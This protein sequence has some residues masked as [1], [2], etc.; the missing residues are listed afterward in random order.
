MQR[1]FKLE[2]YVGKLIMS[3]LNTYVKLRDDQVA[4]SIWEGDVILN[5]LELRCESVENLFPIPVGLRLG[6]VRELRI[7]VPWTKLNS[8]NIVISLHTVECVLTLK[9]PQSC[10]LT[11][12]PVLSSTEPP[13]SEYNPDQNI[14]P[15]YLQSYLHRLLANIRIVVYN[16]SIKF[17]LD[18]IVL[19]LSCNL[20][21]FYPT[22]HEWKITFQ[23]TPSDSST[24]VRR[25]LQVSDVTICL[26]HCGP[27]GYV[28]TYEQPLVYRFS[29]SC[30]IELVYPPGL[31]FFKAS[32]ATIT[33][34]DVHAQTLEVRLSP[35]QVHALVR[36]LE[37]FA[38]VH[39]ENVDWSKLAPVNMSHLTE[40]DAEK[41]TKDVPEITDNPSDMSPADQ[42]NQQSWA[43]WMW[44]LVPNILPP[45][46]ELSNS[47]GDD[48]DD[49]QQSGGT[50]PTCV[51]LIHLV[52]EDAKQHMDSTFETPHFPNS[53]SSADLPDLVESSV[54]PVVTKHSSASDL[55]LPV[56]PGTNEPSISLRRVRHRIR[57][58]RRNDDN[59]PLFVVGVF[60]DQLIVRLL[61][62]NDQLMD[63]SLARL[64]ASSSK[65][66]RCFSQSGLEVTVRGLALQATSLGAHFTS[67]QLGA[68]HISA[69]PIGPSC[70][71]GY[72]DLA[73]TFVPED[74]DSNSPSPKASVEHS[75]QTFL[76]L[77]DPMDAQADPVHL[78]RVFH[79]VLHS[80]T[81]FDEDPMS[82]PPLSVETYLSRFHDSFVC[83]EYPALWFDLITSMDSENPDIRLNQLPRIR[84]GQTDGVTER[85][86]LRV[87]SNQSLVYLSPTILHRFEAFIKS[88]KRHPRYPCCLK[89]SSPAPSE[90]PP[91]IRSQL[92][93]FFDGIAVQT[94]RVVI[95]SPTVYYFAEHWNNNFTETPHLRFQSDNITW[96]RI[97]PLYPLEV[98]NHLK[99]WR[100]SETILRRMT[101]CLMTEAS[102]PTE[103]KPSGVISSSEPEI[104]MHAFRRGCI[105]LSTVLLHLLPGTVSPSNEI[106]L[107]SLSKLTWY[108]WTLNSPELWSHSP[109]LSH[110]P[111]FEWRLV[112]RDSLEIRL[113]A[114]W[115]L[116]TVY[117]ATSVATQVGNLARFLSAST[118]RDCP[119]FASAGRCEGF[120]FT[121]KSSDSINNVQL[122]ADLPGVIRARTFWNSS[123]C[124]YQLSVQTDLAVY[125]RF[126]DCGIIVPI[127][128]RDPSLQ[129][130]RPCF[131]LNDGP[132]LHPAED[133]PLVGLACQFPNDALNFSIP[134]LF[135]VSVCGLE[136]HVTP[137]LVSWFCFALNICESDELSLPG[138][139]S[140]PV[141]HEYGFPWVTTCLNQGSSSSVSEPISAA[142][143]LF[144]PIPK[145]V[146]PAERVSR[147][148]TCE[149]FC[150][151]SRL[152]TDEFQHTV[153]GDP[154]SWLTIRRFLNGTHQLLMKTSIQISMMPSKLVVSANPVTHQVPGKILH[155]G[156]RSTFFDPVSTTVSLSELL[157]NNS[158][159]DDLPTPT[160]PDSFDSLGLVSSSRSWLDATSALPS[161]TPPGVPPKKCGAWVLCLRNVCLKVDKQLL[162][163]GT[164]LV[165]VDFKLR[166]PQGQLVHSSVTVASSLDA[167]VHAQLNCDDFG[168]HDLEMPSVL[169]LFQLG[170]SIK[171]L[172][173]SWK[174]MIP[175]L[176]LL[177]EWWSN[178]RV[179]PTSNAS[180][181]R[182]L[183]I[184]RTALSSGC[185][186]R[187]FVSSYRDDHVAYWKGP[188][189][190]VPHA[191]QTSVSGVRHLCLSPQLIVT[192]NVPPVSLLF[193]FTIPTAIGRLKLPPSSGCTTT[194][195]W[196]LNQLVLS[197]RLRQDEFI[198]DF[199]I[200]SACA[201]FRGQDNAYMPLF[202]TMESSLRPLVDGELPTGLDSPDVP[203]IPESSTKSPPSQFADSESEES[204]FGTR[205]L[206]FLTKSAFGAQ[207][208]CYDSLSQLASGKE[209]SLV[210]LHFCRSSLPPYQ[211][212]HEFCTSTLSSSPVQFVNTLILNVQ[213]VDL[214]LYTDM[215]DE[216]VRFYANLYPGAD[217]SMEP[218]DHSPGAE[219]EEPAAAV[220]IHVPTTT[221]RS[222]ILIKSFRIFLPLSKDLTPQISTE[223]PLANAVVLGCEMIE[224][225]PLV[226]NKLERPSGKLASSQ[227]P[228]SSLAEHE[229]PQQ[230]IVVA[231]GLCC[232]ASEFYS[233]LLPD[234]FGHQKHVLAE[235]QNP[236]QYWNQGIL[237]TSW[238]CTPSPAA[239][240]PLV[241]PFTL[242]ASFAPASRHTNNTVRTYGSA[243]E[244]AIPDNLVI[245]ADFTV[246]EALLANT[247]SRKQSEPSGPIQETKDDWVCS[248]QVTI[249]NDSI[250]TAL[251]RF[252]FTLRH[253]RLIVWRSDSVRKCT[254]QLVCDADHTHM[255]V[256]FKSTYMLDQLNFGVHDVQVDARTVTSECLASG[257]YCP[258]WVRCHPLRFNGGSYQHRDTLVL[259]PY[260]MLGA[261]PS[262]L[263]STPSSDLLLRT[264][265]CEPDPRTGIFSPLVSARI[266]R[267]KKAFTKDL[268]QDGTTD[269][270]FG[271]SV[272]F[273]RIV[274]FTI[275]PEIL[276][277]F[278]CLF[279]IRDTN[280][281]GDSA[282]RSSQ[283]HMPD[284][285][286]YA[287]TW[288]SQ[289]S[290]DTDVL[291]ILLEKTNCNQA[292]NIE[293]NIRKTH[294]NSTFTPSEGFSDCARW[295][296]D[297]NGLHLSC[298]SYNRQQS[299]LGLSGS[300]AS[301]ASE[302]VN[303]HLSL[304][305]PGTNLHCAGAVRVVSCIHLTP[306]RPSRFILET[307]CLFTTGTGVNVDIPIC[308]PVFSMIT[309]LLTDFSAVFPLPSTSSPSLS[310]KD[311]FPFCDQCAGMQPFLFHDDLRRGLPVQASSDDRNLK[312][313]N[314]VQLGPLHPC[315]PW[316][317]NSVDLDQSP[318]CPHPWPLAGEVVF[319]DNMQRQYHFDGHTYPIVLNCNRPVD[320]H[321]VGVTWA[322]SDPRTPVRVRVLPAPFEFLEH[323][324]NVPYSHG[325][326][327]RCH[328]QYWDYSVMPNGKFKDYG[329]FFLRDSQV[330]DFLL[331]NK[332]IAEV[333]RDDSAA[334]ASVTQ[335]DS[336]MRQRVSSILD[337]AIQK[338]RTPASLKTG[339]FTFKRSKLR[340]TNGGIRVSAHVWRIMVDL[341]AQPVVLRAQGNGHSASTSTPPITAALVYISPLV[342][343]G[344][345]ELDSVRQAPTVPQMPSMGIFYSPY[346]RIGLFRQSENCRQGFSDCLELARLELEN[347][348]VSHELTGRNS[349]V[350]SAYHYGCR[351]TSGHCLLADP[352][353]A[354]L[355]PAAHV[356]EFDS[357]VTRIS[358]TNRCDVKLN[359]CDIHILLGVD[360]LTSLS[361]LT[362]FLTHTANT[363]RS[364]CSLPIGTPHIG[365]G[366]RVANYSDQIVILRQTGLQSRTSD[367][368]DHPLLARGNSGLDALLLFVIC[369]AATE[370]W[371]PLPLPASA[372]QPVASGRIR[373]HVGTHSVH[374]NAENA[375][376]S[377]AVELAWPPCR[378]DSQHGS[379]GYLVLTLSWESS[380]SKRPRSS[381]PNMF[382]IL[383]QPDPTGFPGRIIF[384]SDIVFRNLIPVD[385]R[386]QLS[387]EPLPVDSV[388]SV[389]P[390]E[391]PLDR[392]EPVK[393]FQLTQGPSENYVCSS[394]SAAC[395]RLSKL[396]HTFRLSTSQSEHRVD[397]KGRWSEPSVFCHIPFPSRNSRRRISQRS[398]VGIPID[399]EDGSDLFYAVVT[400]ESLVI[401]PF[402][403]LMCMVTISPSFNIVSF[404]PH[405]F[406]LCVRPVY[407]YTSTAD[408][409][410]ELLSDIKP[411][412]MHQI[413]P[414]SYPSRPPQ[415]EKIEL[416]K[417][418]SSPFF[419]GKAPALLLNAYL[420][421][422]I[423]LLSEPIH[424]SPD[425]L[426]TKLAT[427]FISATVP[428]GSMMLNG[429]EIE[430]H[431]HKPSHPVVYTLNHRYPLYRPRSTLFVASE[432]DT[433][434]YTL[435]IIL[436]PRLRLFN[437]SGADLC[438][439]FLSNPKGHSTEVHEFPTGSVI[440]PGSDKPIVQFGFVVKA[441]AHWS[442]VTFQLSP[443]LV[444][445]PM[446]DSLAEFPNIQTD[447]TAERVKAQNVLIECRDTDTLECP[448]T[449]VE[450]VEHSN[451]MVTVRTESEGG[452]M[453][454]TIFSDRILLCL[455]ARLIKE[456]GF[457]LIVESQVR[458]HH[459]CAPDLYVRPI[460]LSGERQSTYD[461]ELVLSN[462]LVNQTGLR[463]TGNL[464][465]LPYWTLSCSMTN[466]PE[467][468]I[469]HKFALWIG[470][471][472]TKGVFCE[473]PNVLPGGTKSS[474]STQHIDPQMLYLPT[475]GTDMENREYDLIV[476]V[477][478]ISC[479]GQVVVQL[480]DLPNQYMNSPV[481]VR[482]VNQT[483]VDLVVSVNHTSQHH[484]TNTGASCFP[485]EPLLNLPSLG[486]SQIWI[487]NNILNA[488]F[489]TERSQTEDNTVPAQ[490]LPIFDISTFRDYTI[491]LG[492]KSDSHS[493]GSLVFIP[494]ASL[495]ESD[496]HHTCLLAQ[497]GGGP[498]TVQLT[499]QINSPLGPCLFIFPSDRPPSMLPEISSFE[500]S[501]CLRLKQLQVS[502]LVFEPVNSMRPS[503]PRYT[504]TVTS[505]FCLSGSLAPP[506]DEFVRLLLRNLSIDS[507]FFFSE[508]KINQ[509]DTVLYTEHIQLDNW[510]QTWTS[511]YD[512]PTVFCSTSPAG[513]CGRFRTSSHTLS[514]PVC[515]LFFAPPELQLSLED[516]LLYDLYAL[517]LSFT[518]VWSLYPPQLSSRA[519]TPQP[520]L[521]LFLQHFYVDR[522][523]LRVSLRVMLRVY[524]SCHEAPLSVAPFD[525]NKQRT[526]TSA[527]GVA[528]TISTLGRLLGVHYFT[529][530]MFRAGWLVGSLDVLGNISG[531]LHSLLCGL[532]ALVN[533]RSQTDPPSSVVSTSHR[534]L[535]DSEISAMTVNGDPRTNVEYVFLD[536]NS[537][538]T[539][540]SPEELDLQRQ[541]TIRRAALLRRFSNGIVSLTRHTTGGLIRSVTG[542]A[543]SVARNL[544]HLSLD[545]QHQQRQEEIRRKQVPRGLGEGLQRGLSGFGLC[546]L[547]AIAGVAD[548]PLQALF[549]A[550]DNTPSP[551]D[552][553]DELTENT[554][555]HQSSHLALATLGGLGRGLVGA[556]VKPMAGV[557]ELVAQAGTGILQASRLGYPSTVTRQANGPYT[558]S[559]VESL[560]QCL[561]ADTLLLRSW[562]L[563]ALKVMWHGE[564]SHG[565]SNLENSNDLW[566]QLMWVAPALISQSYSNRNGR[567]TGET[568]E[569]I[570]VCAAQVP[571]LVGSLL[572]DRETGSF[573]LFT[574]MAK[575]FEHASESSTGHPPLFAGLYRKS[576]GRGKA[577][578]WLSTVRVTPKT[579]QALT[580]IASLFWPPVE[581]DGRD[582]MVTAEG[583]SCTVPVPLTS[584]PSGYPEPHS[585]LTCIGPRL[586]PSRWQRVK[587]Y[588][589][590]TNSAAPI[591]I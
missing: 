153:F 8:E 343:A 192:T 240:S 368:P 222:Y 80:P 520:P 241:R 531:L 413:L 30:L 143:S 506:Q 590:S 523:D 416:P 370:T 365:L 113:P 66:S 272:I 124:V 350:Q 524:L 180:C 109:D 315:W 565:M 362:S 501:L 566:K 573:Q 302:C 48:D 314:P 543:A 228:P 190:P 549:K 282:T 519:I 120:P 202:S 477:Q 298:C 39:T 324:A 119:T 181:F 574:L 411:P 525:L 537:D 126:S 230:V 385:I 541:I 31:D 216:I 273:G 60:T 170:T 494:L 18:D 377:E 510:G 280:Q 353:W 373:F 317:V 294:L 440:S 249:P 415:T 546:V 338:N 319:C 322:Y 479:D 556:V 137:E 464:F 328:L 152:I 238:N 482:L 342:L 186:R 453:R 438:V 374:A 355:K 210:H 19:S 542:M 69:F 403:P 224:I 223:A 62:P 156:F 555:L 487:P 7:H 251:S 172:V 386:A 155:Q 509:L 354:K 474:N 584:P 118:A 463:P 114:D 78:R 285:I 484:S 283:H 150:S 431:Y 381:Y 74:H 194:V 278:T 122:C 158:K 589:L 376:W 184:T 379:N 242:T 503:D 545:Q 533:L 108:S 92:P 451:S 217:A 469:Q 218:T 132:Y 209:T 55:R 166:F 483:N 289:L 358:D 327:L 88:V 526:S 235:Q 277:T 389:H 178:N 139:N 461:E 316:V 456:K 211:H 261:W 243:T 321:W 367:L 185:A 64:N 394:S 103:A 226:C 52:Y 233:L 53:F 125:L 270:R 333:R 247:Q 221:F 304:L 91:L 554:G 107:L 244:V 142:S 397:S 195:Y 245:F 205:H 388:P 420:P 547:G 412:W 429:S 561:A 452:R 521:R 558:T 73:K 288:I 401:S 234:T 159:P 33:T 406:N 5:E 116:H 79:S 40:G 262:S 383:E 51:D 518:R 391:I 264:Q 364:S 140:R 47:D 38:A 587:E 426:L 138:K 449:A 337:E 424:L 568:G 201:Q 326:E 553:W 196:L 312:S 229:D 300:S 481:A 428:T 410:P 163:S 75:H 35:H 422:G 123:C 183:S 134:A 189:D 121:R 504:P 380:F 550:V 144:L 497:V 369:P 248:P 336:N 207:H 151:S 204:G 50:R 493:S 563:A 532:D 165:N 46:T 588:I 508:H 203:L 445:S 188:H 349:I 489:S 276:V 585:S 512:F 407:P 375:V 206:T 562:A 356:R 171:F 303:H 187:P 458:I 576:D 295:R 318:L 34:M 535:S 409:T 77:G 198:V 10:G 346:V 335:E 359:L 11:K 392:V 266:E 490:I 351:F 220:D 269:Q 398:L 58:L 2:T 164:L 239:A 454:F 106:P 408:N 111:E 130:S 475:T 330:V 544:D 559:A 89:M 399:R 433:A 363:L 177:S 430:H 457:I 344:C 476:V 293:L 9:K 105:R 131:T 257:D 213:P 400:V 26:D 102:W 329:T 215:I 275:K 404:L 291:N 468:V 341:R 441:E 44:S 310:N 182:D 57:H 231:R 94:I 491:S 480:N 70:P 299:P 423:S 575:D 578:R 290:V 569:L 82:L 305:W 516:S 323:L 372:A 505:G 65:F 309:Q 378:A 112:S 135:R 421:N 527:V 425:N 17:L 538:G 104:F 308:G 237:R 98:F 581:P 307:E 500:L 439:R 586:P 258:T 214:V 552:P 83:Q 12:A 366:W 21:D 84:S 252:L 133:V 306:S 147:S 271:V 27:T 384:H 24:F 331:L 4:M 551:S 345:V 514:A 434:S 127:V 197:L 128:R 72:L 591:T 29:L 515:H 168:P 115:L 255:A 49:I 390:K 485:P 357:I 465:P 540:S 507:C 22:T 432:L 530:A 488:L 37:V 14:A 450:T 71:C 448:R 382:L 20:L 499:I 580:N 548:H 360:R 446:L 219:P 495:I 76:E 100:F 28:E 571:L 6:R 268:S 583:G 3:Y 254:A 419:L 570:W 502:L 396:L 287:T 478:S 418:V 161:I 582:D 486:G 146:L 498:V 395:S 246:L 470:S 462:T 148:S 176:K 232:W 154:A 296:V 97:T 522:C 311:L 200:G 340:A 517:I 253:F 313:S 393:T 227:Y 572:P 169:H 339:D 145:S 279:D 414:P 67:V 442:N 259:P 95:A 352:H 117:L 265:P 167:C 13:S 444:D 301:L 54:P 256:H 193:H 564:C 96:S 42:G 68:K 212:R 149:S 263:S 471:S 260:I 417:T 536:N 443:V 110:L 557:A 274:C 81:S 460:V 129:S 467:S 63:K 175:K 162:F 534:F 179:Q 87:L 402:A 405:S 427:S 297:L 496:A 173:F 492:C 174:L 25:K 59:Q 459:R 36:L 1:F 86:H 93:Q 472:K 528:L 45:N 157:L 560:S 332:R 250:D 466:G 577:D 567:E 529:Q 267:P 292:G 15:G 334:S 191:P 455:L 348:K 539:C 236:A 284:A 325:L 361:Y 473:I 436:H 61:L 513:F 23:S 199:Q 281:P 286:H 447:G 435:Q 32:L 85:V 99:R 160:Y 141:E 320:P 511:T 90:Y 43:S 208:C 225:Q 579:L 101:D 41:T 437:Q 387:S 347:L 371:R 16:L 56:N 136:G